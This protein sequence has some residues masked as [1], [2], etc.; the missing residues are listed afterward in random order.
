[1]RGYAVQVCSSEGAAVVLRVRG[2]IDISSAGELLDTIVC[3]AVG[4]AAEV[5]L[6]LTEVT[7]FDSS[8]IAA[9]V[10]A[11]RRL[12]ERDVAVGVV[13]SSPAVQHVLAL[14]GVDRLMAAPSDEPG[15]VLQSIRQP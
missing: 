10:K 1:M 2:E 11:H 3:A 14:T 9:L 7:F 13:G 5:Q 12:S 6:D 15:P 8:G 4:G